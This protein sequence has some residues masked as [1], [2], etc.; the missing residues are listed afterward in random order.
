MRTMTHGEW[1]ELLERG[2]E[3][4]EVRA[5]AEAVAA[6]EGRAVVVEGAAG[7]GKT[8]LLAEVRTLAC[9]TGLRPWGA[10]ATELERAFGFGVARQ[11][12]EPAVHDSDGAAA[13]E[14]AARQ[15]A[16]LLDVTSA[17]PAALPFG[18]E[19]TFAVL[20]GLYRLTA[21]LARQQPLALLVDDAH[22]ADAASLRFLAYLAG[23]ISHEPVMLVVAARPRSEPGGAAV[24]ELLA[25]A[26]APVLLRLKTL[27][28]D[29]SARLVRSVVPDA[30][31]SVCRSCHALTHGNPFFLRELA[32]ALR[33][34][35]AAHAADVLGT[36]PD[37]VVASVG[38]RLA[39]FPGLPEGS[40]APPPSWETARSCG[41]PRRSR[42]SMTARPPRRPTRSGRG[43][44]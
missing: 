22:W 36:A 21:N 43:G 4:S 24:A 27:S 16:E 23:R 33:E 25:E 31:T 38:A 11:L 7:I 30:L 9:G 37:G 2:G 29:A 32:G 44:S 41:T 10:R 42:S 3:L 39:R 14:G 28:D 26:G 8:A 13:F 12:L 1:G 20:H 17:E 19:R 40:S 18:P 6:G 15:A 34:A 5:I 35:G